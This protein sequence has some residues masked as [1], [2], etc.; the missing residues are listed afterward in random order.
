MVPSQDWCG[1]VVSFTL[2][3]TGEA[4]QGEVFCVEPA[5]STLVLIQNKVGQHI[6]SYRYLKF[7]AM[8][9]ASVKLAG[10]HVPPEP[11]PPLSDAIMKRIREKEADAVER[12]K[13]RA[14]EQIGSG[15]SREAQLLFNGL[16]KTMPC[17]WTGKTIMV[18]AQ[19]SDAGARIEEPY[20]ADKVSG[21]NAQFVERLKKVLE[22]ERAKL[23]S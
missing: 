9:L 23:S 19:R 13:Q 11:L 4:V 5:S 7:Q 2:K 18:D 22:G 1:M 6:A 14:K 15:V 20:T 16:A 8:D 17:K 3:A 12:E 10:S 21:Q